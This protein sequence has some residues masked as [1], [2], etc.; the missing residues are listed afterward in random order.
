MLQVQCVMD[1]TLGAM[2]SAPKGALHA[3]N[4]HQQSQHTTSTH[5]ATREAICSVMGLHHVIRR[6]PPLGVQEAS[7]TNMARGSPSQTLYS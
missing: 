1:R 6:G 2:T 5:E 4:I 3:I 7:T